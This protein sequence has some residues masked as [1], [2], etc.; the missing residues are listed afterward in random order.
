MLPD[1]D[2]H[3]GKSRC[4]DWMRTREGTG[5]AF[6]VELVASAML[7]VVGRRH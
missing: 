4:G 2:V 5:M 1:D 6:G 7:V 3:E